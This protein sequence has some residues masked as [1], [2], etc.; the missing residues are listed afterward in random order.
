MGHL[1][2]LC[3]GALFTCFVKNQPMLNS[4]FLPVPQGN[5]L[6]GVH[7]C[8]YVC[9]C[10]WYSPV[11]TSGRHICFFPALS[12]FT[13][14]GR[15]YRSKADSAL[16]QNGSSSSAQSCFRILYV[17]VSHYYLTGLEG[18]QRIVNGISNDDTD[19]A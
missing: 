3:P 2:A 10:L 16:I 5:S 7:V 9:V 1:T 6:G 14:Q 17:S 18:C 15:E 8:S 13:S 19:G 11:I 12:A 4:V